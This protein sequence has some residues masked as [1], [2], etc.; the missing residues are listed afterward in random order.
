MASFIEEYFELKPDPRSSKY[1][2]TGSPQ[3][4]LLVLIG[5]IVFVKLLGPWL[6]KNREPFELK[7]LIRIYNVVQIVANSALVIR[8]FPIIFMEYKW[9]GRCYSIDETNPNTEETI[10]SLIHGFCLL[11]FLDLLDTVF[12][13]LRKRYHQVTFLHFYHH[14]IVALMTPPL[15]RYVPNGHLTIL[16]YLNSFVHTV[17]YFYYLISNLKPEM[18][19]SIWWKKYITL[20]QIL[21]F[22][23]LMG[24]FLYP[25]SNGESCEYPFKFLYFALAQNVLFLIMFSNFF[26]I[27]YCKKK[28][29]KA[30]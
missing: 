28:I 26:Y 18:K 22:V 30:M 5:Y 17:M 14:L 25:V 8:G 9:T 4:T 3:Q 15:F 27:T 11:K 10:L 29:N 24:F 19:N 6:M 7:A 2:L 12:F 20:L 21:Q 23:F 13:I 16:G 1:F